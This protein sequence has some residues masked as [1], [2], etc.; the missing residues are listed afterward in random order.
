VKVDTSQNPYFLRFAQGL[1]GVEDF[2]HCRTIAFYERDVLAVVVYNAVEDK[3]CGISIAANNPKWC[4]RTVLRCSFGYPFIQ[5]G[6]NRV[7][8]VIR[9]SNERALSLNQRLGFKHEGEMREY[10]DNGESAMIYGLTKS[11]CKWI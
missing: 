7:T 5:L 1:T 6:L 11:E 3:N 10:Y 9:A 2:G 4:T 8:G